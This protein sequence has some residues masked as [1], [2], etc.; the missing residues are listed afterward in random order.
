MLHL[1]RH[2]PISTC[3]DQDLSINLD[4]TG[5]ELDITVES[6]AGGDTIGD[7]DVEREPKHTPHNWPTWLKDFKK[8][9]NGLVVNQCSAR[10]R[11]AVESNEKV[12]VRIVIMVTN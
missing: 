11:R 3:S 10:A 7:D 9:F 4:V 8:G 5:D 1:L 12:Q 2:P 6:S